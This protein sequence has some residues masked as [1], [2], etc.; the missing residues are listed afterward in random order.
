MQN[1]C[2]FSIQ[3]TLAYSSVFK[4]PLS[5][6]QLCTY[7]IGNKGYSFSEISESLGNLVKKGYVKNSNG[8]YFLPGTK[9]VNW[10]QKFR[11]SLEVYKKNLK[12]IKNLSRIP[13]IKFIGITGSLANYSADKETDID[14]F[15]IT[16]KNRV[17]LSRGFVF[18]ILK[19]LRKLPSQNNVKREYCPNIFVDEK[20]MCWDKSKRNLY[21][22]QNIVSIQPVFQRD[23]MYFRFISANAWIKKHYPNF[24]I[25]TPKRFPGSRNSRSEVLGLLEFMANKLQIRYMKSK[26]TSEVLSKGIIHFNKNDKSKHIMETYKNTLT[27]RKIS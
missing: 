10:N 18:I 17:W 12:V 23:N 14:L 3:R 11:Y 19:I 20:N 15:F 26:I 5:F 8:K 21:V 22:A 27:N 1:S 6:Y 9:V 2:E 4:Y 16:S 13:W 25:N 7:L 24:Y